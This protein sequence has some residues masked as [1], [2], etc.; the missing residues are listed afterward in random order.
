VGDSWEEKTRVYFSDVVYVESHFADGVFK[1]IVLYGV[2]IIFLFQNHI[3]ILTWFCHQI[4]YQRK[5]KLN[6]FEGAYPNIV[7]GFLMF[8]FY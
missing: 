1:F 4:K 3:I 6:H 8:L 2:K 7:F 5:I